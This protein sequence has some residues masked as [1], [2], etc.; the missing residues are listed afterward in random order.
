MV[1]AI[2][3]R[4]DIRYDNHDVLLGTKMKSGI[5][6]AELLAGIPESH[7]S[8]FAT[9]AKET[10][11]VVASRAVGIYAT[12]LI[13][14]GYATKGYHVKAKSCDW[15]P[16]AGFVLADPSL[17][18][19]GTGGD[20]RGWQEGKVA[21]AMNKYGAM[22]LPLYISA[23][24]KAGLAALM[25]RA[26]KT[27]NEEKIDD[28]T[29]RVSAAAKDGQLHEF[30]LVKVTSIAQTSRAYNPSGS[31]W[32]VC[33]GEDNTLVTTCSEQRKH[34]ITTL[35]GGSYTQLCGLTNPLGYGAKAPAN[36]KGVQTGDYDL[37]GVFPKD[38]FFSDTEREVVLAA[39]N[40]RKD[41]FWQRDVDGSDQFIKTYKEYTRQEGAHTGNLSLLIEE[42]AVRVNTGCMKAGSGGWVVHHS[43]EAGRPL[44]DEVDYEAVVYFPDGR[45]WIMES[46]QDVKTLRAQLVQLDYVPLFNPIW[47]FK[48]GFQ[49]MKI[50][51]EWLNQHGTMKG[52]PLKEYRNIKLGF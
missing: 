35:S 15:G 36:C 7:S 11:T 43:D 45:I 26:G 33:Y 18:K 3:Y 50:L 8:V 27:Y 51:V 44:V 10:N 4:D 14:E 47:N 41:S 25:L 1:L 17:G 2:T 23:E 30:I 5:E 46:E 28:N 37:W 24:R 20:A 40:G 52:F 49:W 6:N 32:A 39:T 9:V 21:E 48:L 38:R 16:M 29:Y 31:D 13:L 34:S 19:K 42:I 12:Q 22:A